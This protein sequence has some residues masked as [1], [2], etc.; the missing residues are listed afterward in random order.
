[1]FSKQGEGKNS[2]EFAAAA[3]FPFP[4][5]NLILEK[6]RRGFAIFRKKSHRQTTCENFVKISPKKFVSTQKL[7]LTLQQVVFV[8]ICLG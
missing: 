6:H 3:V 8:F 5:T 4:K 7:A 1:M 2:F